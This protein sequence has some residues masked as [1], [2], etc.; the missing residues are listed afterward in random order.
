MLSIENLSVSFGENKVLDDIS[1]K[2]EKGKVLG[3]V[4]ESGSG[5]TMTALTIMRLLAE[6]AVIEQGKVLL[7]GKDILGL[8][9]K[10]M[11]DVRGN[12]VA[13]I[14]QEP[15]TSLN[16]TM[17]IGEQIREALTIH[18]KPEKNKTFSKINIIQSI[19]YKKI[20]R[21]KEYE[22]VYEV[23]EAVRLKNPKELYN[24]YPH[25]LSGGM[26]QRVM[27]AMGLILHPDYLICDEPTTAL[28]VTTQKGILELIASLK[29]EYNMGVIFI[30]HD[31]KLLKNFADEIVVMKKGKIVESGTPEEIFN[32][33]KEAYTKKLI[34]SI[35]NRENRKRSIV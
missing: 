19:K 8:T 3:I 11:C 23:L 12:E 32:T 15:M 10:Q 27:I 18:K 14:F 9:H 16:P 17:V 29:E 20:Q 30:T 34:L 26:R 31:L 28:D 1:M 25:E 22:Q 33:P 2:L 13:M 35:P 5:K 6:N 7:N 21:K 24:K 4:G